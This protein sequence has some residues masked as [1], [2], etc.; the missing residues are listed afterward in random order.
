LICPNCGIENPEGRRFCEECGEKMTEA[1]HEREVSRRKTSREAARIRREAEAKGLDA[2]TLERRRRGRT[3]KTKPWMGLVLL[4]AVIL[5]VIVVVIFATSSSMSAPE[6]VTHDF[7]NAIKNKNVMNFL[8]TTTEVGTY[9]QVKKGEIPAPEAQTYIG[10][11]RYDVKDLKTVLVSQKD[12]R[13]E[14][15]IVGG[16]FQGFWADNLMAPS[17]GVDFAQYPRIVKLVKY[18]DSW[19]IENYSEVMVPAPLPET[20]SE[21]NEFPELEGNP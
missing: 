12:D 17:T 18:G 1:V 8:K 19:V 13:A 21:E 11:D 14:V 5:I 6:K 16:W 3:R 9:E 10:Y 7:F 4:A 20:S 15:R 2:E